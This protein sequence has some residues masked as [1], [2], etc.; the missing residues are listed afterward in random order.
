LELLR[1]E[2]ATV[3]DEVAVERGLRDLRS[4]IEDA[5]AQVP[6]LPAIA[7]RLE[8]GQE[9]LRREI[10]TTQGKLSRVRTN[11]CI[12]DYRLAELRKATERRSTALELKIETTVSSFEMR[13]V[14]PAARAG[15]RAF[16]AETLK[17]TRDD[18][19]LWL[20]DPNPRPRAG[21]A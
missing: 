12:T 13:E 10:E 8:A 4:E 14:H 11:Q 9:R 6:K 15:L 17:G 5:R 3:R 7:A 1:R 18:G 16:A 21:A 2:L 19:K 20:F